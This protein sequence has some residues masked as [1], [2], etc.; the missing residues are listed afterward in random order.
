M[1]PEAKC[2]VFF[3]PEAKVRIIDVQ[4]GGTTWCIRRG[5]SKRVSRLATGDLSEVA[6]GRHIDSS[7]VDESGSN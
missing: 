1:E 4:H 6:H 5:K 3:C 7:R 2:S